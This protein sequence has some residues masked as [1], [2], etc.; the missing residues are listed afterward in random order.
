M[1]RAGKHLDGGGRLPAGPCLAFSLCL[2]V[3]P[4]AWAGCGAVSTCPLPAASLFCANGAGG[5]WSLP[6]RLGTL[7]SLQCC[8]YTSKINHRL[9][10]EK[11]SKAFNLVNSLV[12]NKYS[13]NLKCAL[14]F[15][16]KTAQDQLSAVSN[17]DHFP[18]KY[19]HLKKKG[20]Y[21]RM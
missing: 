19:L 2:A 7:L 11:Y 17:W 16:V 12:E 18:P 10:K 8:K 15:H 13:N 3:W 9:Q 4:L 1:G 21:F 20:L 5:Q 14:H 6:R